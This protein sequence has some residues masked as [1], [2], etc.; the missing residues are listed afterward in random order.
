MK[1]PELIRRNSIFIVAAV[2]YFFLGSLFHASGYL[3][4]SDCGCWNSAVNGIVNGSF[5]IYTFVGSPLVA[6]PHG[7]TFDYPGLA[8]YLMVPAAL[9]AKLLNRDPCV[10]YG[11]IFILLDILC[12]WE[13]RRTITGL[14]PEIS[15]KII[16]FISIALFGSYVLVHTSAYLNHFDSVFVYFMIVGIRYIPENRLMSGLLFGLAMATKQVVVIGLIP[17]A[18]LLLKGTFNARLIRDNL[19]FY[20]SF[21]TAFGVFFLPFYFAD[22]HRAVWAVFEQQNNRTI[23]WWSTYRLL[24]LLTVNVTVTLIVEKLLLFFQYYS[25]YLIIFFSAISTYIVMKYNFQRNLTYLFGIFTFV[26]LLIPL[27]GK[28]SLP[29]YALPAVLFFVI[30]D[31]LR[32]NKTYFF[33]FF[34]MAFLILQGRLYEFESIPLLDL[35]NQPTYVSVFGSVV[36]YSAGFL[37]VFSRLLKEKY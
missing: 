17:I 6:P 13:I 2:V 10:F 9:F 25:N 21:I 12:V 5:E 37:Y 29:S 26:F 24:D 35:H 22:P 14:K 36:L 15:L 28:W 23:M 3:S 11:F 1:L 31:C 4:R 20:L 16:E 27:L 18:L 7:N 33:P 30:W 34:S 19:S 32:V 8:A